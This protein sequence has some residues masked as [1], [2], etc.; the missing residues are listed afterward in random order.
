[1]ARTLEQ[2]NTLV[3]AMLARLN[4]L[5]GANLPHPSEASTA[6]LQAEIDGLRQTVNQAV[7]TLDAHLNDLDRTIAELRALLHAH[8]G[9]SV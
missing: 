2:T 8:L 3:D 6:V 9:I 5:D 1:M 4:Q 7:L